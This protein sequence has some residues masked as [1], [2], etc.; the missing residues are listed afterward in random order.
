MDTGKDPN[1]SQTPAP[2][3]PPA[4]DYTDR[5]I[6][7]YRLLRRIGQG[8]MGQVFLAE[9]L[10][11][12]RKV[13]LKILKAD[14]AANPSALKRFKAEAET[15]ARATHANIV[16]VYAIDKFE[17]LH[18]MALEYVEG[19]NLRQYLEKKGPPDILLALSIMRQVAAALQ[20]AS[21][22]GIIHRDIK[23][24]NIL[25]TRKGEVK[26]ADFGL[27]RSLTGEQ[28]AL[29]LTQS[30]VVMGT[31]LYM[32]PEQVEGKAVDT[33]TD[34]Y[35]FGVTCYHMMAGQPPFQ[36]EGAFAVALKH[37]REEP[38]PLR[39][40]R[41]D[42]PE[43][44]CGV[45][46]KM[47]AKNPDQRYQTCRELFKDLTRVRE[48]LG[49]ATTAVSLPS[50]SVEVVPPP[51][52]EASAKTLVVPAPAPPRSVSPLVAAAT[53]D[54]QRRPL[55][56][57]LAGSSI[58]AA[59]MAGCAL[60]GLQA[61]AASGNHAVV[62]AT[63]PTS[64]NPGTP[65]EAKEI[66]AIIYSESPQRRER[67]LRDAIDVF[68]T[69]NPQVGLGLCLE[70]AVLYF[71]Q[72]R[73]DDAEKFFARL[74]GVGIRD[75][76]PYPTLV[77]F[78]RAIVLALRSQQVESNKLFVEIARESPFTSKDFPIKPGPAASG[79]PEVAIWGTA[80]FKFWIAQ[81]LY[82]NEKNGLPRKEV[83]EFFQKFRDSLP[84]S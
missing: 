75:V 70:L 71:E 9:Q 2:G 1:P 48:S 40:I 61:F 52:D 15:V 37:V 82:Y 65:A 49:G 80:P 18:F 19:R 76:R 28:I 33:R 21:E 62:L 39:T 4:V 56:W 57:L 47:M 17:D 5:T 50:A 67:A 26:V 23:P 78:G 81:A 24:E 13:A 34:I 58:V 20:R 29:N 72:D 30:G 69:K 22:L 55:V 25:L 14:V 43:L 12:K 64:A 46:Q 63:K 36:G 84:K 7:D 38:T 54:W 51:R 10:S 74:E 77:R 8:G 35:S 31:P 44:F 32:S 42:L 73:L 53:A 79:K 66:E 41:P 60:A 6:G 16:Q 83:P 11:L 68:L 59:L 27:S 45:I 3:T